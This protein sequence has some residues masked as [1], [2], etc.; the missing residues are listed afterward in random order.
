MWLGGTPPKQHE[1]N[2]PRKRKTWS[3]LNARRGISITETCLCSDLVAYT[4]GCGGDRRSRLI[5]FSTAEKQ[6]RARTKKG[7]HPGR[8][9]LIPAN[10]TKRLTNPQAHPLPRA[11][12]WPEIKVWSKFMGGVIPTRIYAPRMMGMCK[13]GAR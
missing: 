6:N 12:A 4:G 9:L 1:R 2:G 3:K 7:T 5:G 8:F 11:L 10:Q 13:G